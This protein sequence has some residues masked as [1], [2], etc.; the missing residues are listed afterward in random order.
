MK[1]NKNGSI[2]PKNE[3]LFEGQILNEVE[4]PK[5]GESSFVDEFKVNYG[6]RYIP[7][8]SLLDIAVGS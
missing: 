8:I 4:K 3:G 2:N 7:E 6:E 5:V 1:E